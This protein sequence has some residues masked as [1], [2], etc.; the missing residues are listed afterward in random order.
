MSADQN[1]AN[2]ENRVA[3]AVDA[4]AQEEAAKAGRREV[5]R[6]KRVF[7]GVVLLVLSVAALVASMAWGWNKWQHPAGTIPDTVVAEGAKFE[8]ELVARAVDAYRRNTGQ[9]PAS[10]GEVARDSAHIRFRVTGD[11]YEL[12]TDGPGGPVRL[13]RSVGR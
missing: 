2:L 11:S 1:N 7:G 4:L 3:N 10:L 12:E 8:L 5:Y 6:P 13:S 9:L